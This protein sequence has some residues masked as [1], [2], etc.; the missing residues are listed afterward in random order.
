MGARAAEGWEAGREEGWVAG[1]LG[2]AQMGAGTEV[3]W[4]AEVV[5]KGR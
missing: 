4:V 1:G 2:A 3:G 5:L